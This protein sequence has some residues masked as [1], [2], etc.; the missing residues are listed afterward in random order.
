MTAID[1]L[2]ESTFNRAAADVDVP[3]GLREHAVASAGR[4]QRRR[5]AA[6]ATGIAAVAVAAVAIAA[7]SGSS[8]ERRA[9]PVESPTPVTSATVTNLVSH[10]PAPT[11]TESPATLDRSSA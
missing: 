9:T 7:V 11:P 8:G 5:R 2:L 10:S 4:I 3:A 6:G 1:E